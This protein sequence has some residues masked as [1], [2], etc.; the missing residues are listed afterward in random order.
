MSHRGPNRRGYVMVLF[1]MLLFGIMAMAALVIDIGFARL[2][3]RQMQTA[4]DSAA[5]EGLRYRDTDG[6]ERASDLV[7]MHFDDDLLE[8]PEDPYNFGAGPIV[9]FTGGAGDASMFA[10]Q[11]MQVPAS[12]TYKPTDQRALKLNAD[13][14]DIAG[15][16]LV[17][18]F[19][20]DQDHEEA[21]DYSRED[22][23]VDPT[24]S[25]FLVRM[26]RTGESFP[27]SSASSSAGPSLPYLFARGSLINRELVSRGVAVRST[28]IAQYMPVVTVGNEDSDNGLLGPLGIAVSLQ[29]W[30]TLST[31]PATRTNP[32]IGDVIGEVVPAVPTPAPSSARRGY[33]AIFSE[34]T[35]R[36][37]IGFGYAIVNVTGDVTKQPL[38]S[39]QVPGMRSNASAV[40]CRSPKGPTDGLADVIDENR[41]LVSR[42]DILL[43]PVSVR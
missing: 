20:V 24:G 15:D 36:R 1:A 2:A 42:D 40:F 17:G 34:L 6:R 33:I 3:Q 11:L 27:V 12:P 23:A 21:N 8:T 35:D 18:D 28:A 5:L 32:A 9:E 19:F 37:V 29:S 10:S 22:F 4:A 41:A 39:G 14:S 26:R 30:S 31:I 43:A 16:M 7:A 25:A 38:V 13:N